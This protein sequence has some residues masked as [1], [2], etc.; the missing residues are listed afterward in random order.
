[1]NY[2]SRISWNEIRANAARFAETWKD[3]KYERGETHTFYNEFFEVFG[4]SRRRVASFEEPVKK[5]SGRQGYIDLFW[6]GV[7]LVEHKSAGRSLIPAKS[8][9]LEYF[10]GLKET[11][12]PRYILLSDFQNF[13]IYDLDEDDASTFTLAD[14]PSH[15]EKFSFV[16]GIQK[17]TFKEIGRAHV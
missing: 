5:L 3:A 7:L 13:E 9:A 2:S 17:R 12:L 1:M 6:K 11:E 16:I 8:Q 14:L 4:V 10:P 15:V